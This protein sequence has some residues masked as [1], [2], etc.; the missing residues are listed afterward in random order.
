MKE[1]LETELNRIKDKDLFRA[2]RTIDS[3]PGREIIVSGRT[4]LNFSSNNYLG[5]STHPVLKEAANNAIN[6]YGCSG[7]SSRLVA[8]N[9]DLHAQLE[10]KIAKF[11]GCEAALVFPSG[12]QT[13]IG[14]IGTLVG[15]GDCIIMDKLNHASMWDAAKLSKA[16]ILVYDHLDIQSLEKVLK[17]TKEY[18]NKL[19]ITESVFSMDGD[20]A[21]L[22]EISDLTKKYNAWFMVDEAHATG[23]FG[24]KGSG[25]TEYCKVHPDI[26]MGTLS[27]ALGSQGGFVCG[28]KILIDY[29]VNRGRSFIYTTAINPGSVAA[30][31]AAVDLIQKESWRRKQ[32]LNNAEYLREELK[33]IGFDTLNS[34]SQIV[35]V[36]TGNIQR[37][38][39]LSGKLFENGIFAPAI[40]PPTV[41]EDKCRIRVSLTSKLEKN[42][43]DKLLNILRGV[44]C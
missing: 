6:K 33:K 25:L 10:E 30:G 1:Y 42:D 2:M 31:L 37:T 11:K 29:L 22:K 39:Q 8:G 16:R 21:P 43:L 5:L 15:E 14:I 40:R 26:V 18:K 24:K 44:G 36:I 13:N 4:Y 23:I 34:Q 28:S 35:P 19:V 32:L 20:L 17:R 38:L 41:P 12:Y 27:K 9:L 7:T 3:E